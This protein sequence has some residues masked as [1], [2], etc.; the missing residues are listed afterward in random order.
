L[1]P[2]IRTLIPY[3][4]VGG[5]IGSVPLVV[6]GAILAFFLLIWSLGTHGLFFWFCS[7]IFFEVPIFLMV[8]GIWFPDPKNIWLG[9]VGTVFWLATMGFM[10]MALR[11]MREFS[12]RVESEVP[13][14]FFIILFEVAVLTTVAV[15]LSL[16]MP[17]ED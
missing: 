2:K 6:I 16:W 3:A 12:Y 15:T 1:N 9:R 14:L 13:T 11:F 4:T 17:I 5:K 8:I 10:N 7:L